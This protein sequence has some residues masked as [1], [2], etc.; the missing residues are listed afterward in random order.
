VQGRG[1]SGSR[2]HH[3]HF[4][5]GTKVKWGLGQFPGMVN[6]HDTSDIEIAQCLF[7]RNEISDDALHATYVQHLAVRDS[8][9]RKSAADAIDIEFSSGTVERVTTLETGDEPLDLMGSQVVVRNCRFIDF[10]GSGVSAGEETNLVLENTLI[11]QGTHGL[12]AKNA[13]TVSVRGTLLYW[14]RV[15][16]R[17]E[18]A[19]VWYSGKARLRGGPLHVVRCAKPVQVAGGDPK[20]V[21]RVSTRIDDTQLRRLRTEV[22]GLADWGEL[23][24]RIAELH[25]RPSW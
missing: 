13:S 25:R 21:K 17:L 19:S 8:L 14:N 15:G 7:E 3:V 9:F 12:L 4:R 18:V 22:L 20:D 5:K 23:D 2:F 11:A 6:L 1:S 24:G 16:V 10:G